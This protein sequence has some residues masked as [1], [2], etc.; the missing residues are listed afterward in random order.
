[1]KARA[2]PRKYKAE[3]FRECERAF[4]KAVKTLLIRR[5]MIKANPANRGLAERLNIM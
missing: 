1:M 3:F 5:E 2:T 4:K